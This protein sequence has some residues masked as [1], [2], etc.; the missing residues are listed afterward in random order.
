M[1]R[2]MLFLAAAV[3]AL[4]DCHRILRF[5]AAQPA[6]RPR[7][8]QMYWLGPHPVCPVCKRLA[9]QPGRMLV[10]ASESGDVG[11]DVLQNARLFI[12]KWDGALY[13]GFVNDSPDG[14]R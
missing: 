9:D 2:R 6:P 8:N 4:V 11:P 13:A 5:H 12:C 3:L 7:S 10:L 14:A 1:N